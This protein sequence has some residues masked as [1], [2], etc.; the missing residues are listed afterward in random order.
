MVIMITI[1]FIML[2]IINNCYLWRAF[3]ERAEVTR[4]LLVSS[5]DLSAALAR[6]KILS[7]TGDGKT[8]EDLASACLWECVCAC[9]QF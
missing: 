5:F 7:K 1:L 2:V 8:I 6:F 3:N 4:T 9:L